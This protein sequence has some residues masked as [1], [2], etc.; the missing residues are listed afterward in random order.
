M[1]YECHNIKATCDTCH[2][3]AHLLLKCTCGRITSL[4]SSA[5]PMC[6]KCIC[7]WK[8]SCTHSDTST[9]VL[10][11]I[12][13]HTCHSISFQLSCMKV[14]SDSVATPTSTEGSIQAQVSFAKEYC[15]ERLV[16]HG[17]VSQI[18]NVCHS[19]E[20]H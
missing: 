9:C 2:T 10:S 6:H 7:E 5:W 12:I 1:C 8:L 19:H 20:R 17:H 14:S 18:A 4:V 16:T 11:V 15:H 13:C 3:L